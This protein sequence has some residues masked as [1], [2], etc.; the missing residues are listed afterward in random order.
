MVAPASAVVG[1]AIGDLRD[2]QRC[3]LQQRGH[4]GDPPILE[5]LLSG[6][7]AALCKL[8]LVCRGLE[9]R[10]GD[11]VDLVERRLHAGVALLVPVGAE[12]G[13]PGV[14]V[15]DVILD[16]PPDLGGE[17]GEGLVAR[18]LQ[19]LEAERLGGIEEEV[20][21][22]AEVVATDRVLDQ[23][24]A[25]ERP[26]VAGEGDGIGRRLAER[27]ED[28]VEG[29][30][31]PELVL[32]DRGEGD[33]LLEDRPEPRPL[34]ITMGDDELVISHA[35]EKILECCLISHCSPCCCV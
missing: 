14:G 33:I 4:R 25:A 32:R 30:A 31:L 2:H 9:D 29:V 28:A 20:A 21:E 35:E 19:H 3:L 13:D 15:E 34:G 26:L 23:M 18:A 24:A 8:S 5:L 10:E 11:R 12:L 16:L 6:E 7:D 22:E 1:G 17:P 27:F